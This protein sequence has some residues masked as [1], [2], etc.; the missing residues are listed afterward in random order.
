MFQIS[1]LTITEQLQIKNKHQEHYLMHIK[2]KAATLWRLAFSLALLIVI[3]ACEDPSSIGGEFA[4]KSALKVDT[5]LVDN[6]T[7]VNYDAYLGKLNRSATG[8]F[9][10]DLF[11]TQEAFSF[12]KPGLIAN[13]DSLV[14]DAQQD[15]VELRLN[16]FL[17]DF[18]GDTTSTVTYN[19]YRVNELW[20]GATYRR[21]DS[22]TYDDSEVIGQFTDADLDT[23]GTV[24]PNL[25]HCPAKTEK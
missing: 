24:K 8:T 2:T 15:T 9:Q 11:G 17:D 19:I 5:V 14:L 1:S 20:R 21:S 3:T 16:M 25:P 12:I 22:L 7:S 10:D 6:L 23:N 13:A 18:Y 4:D